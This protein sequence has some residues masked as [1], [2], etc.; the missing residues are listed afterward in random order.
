MSICPSESSGLNV[1]QVD[2]PEQLDVLVNAL[3]DNTYRQQLYVTVFGALFSEETTSFVSFCGRQHG[4]IPFF[5]TPL[6]N[7]V[8]DLHN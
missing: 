2:I 4:K 1:R 3:A 5:G 6:Y 7:L 8:L